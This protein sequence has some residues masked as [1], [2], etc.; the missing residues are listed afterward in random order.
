MKINNKTGVA[1]TLLSLMGCSG[2]VVGPD[3]QQNIPDAI[4]P[5]ESGP[6]TGAVQEDLSLGCIE[7]LEA[8]PFDYSVA[9]NVSRISKEAITRSPTPDRGLVGMSRAGCEVEESKR[10]V[11]QDAKDSDTFMCYLKTVSSKIREVKLGKNKWNYFEGAMKVYADRPAVDVRVRL[12][13]F[14]S[15]I[16]VDVCSNIPNAGYQRTV[17]LRLNQES[18]ATT[19]HVV[20]VGYEATN[21]AVLKKVSRIELERSKDQAGNVLSANYTSKHFNADTTGNYEIMHGEFSADVRKLT[22][23]FAGNVFNS[24][25]TMGHSNVVTTSRWDSSGY[26]SGKLS[27]VS[28]TNAPTVEQCTAWGVP[29][30]LMDRCVGRCLVNGEGQVEFPDANGKCQTN[31]GRSEAYKIVDAGGLLKHFVADGS[32]S[33]FL[34][35]VSIEPEISNLEDPADETKFSDDWDCKVGEGS[36]AVDS[37]AIDLIGPCGATLNLPSIKSCEAEIWETKSGA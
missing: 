12:G 36:L 25:P 10:M 29:D 17:E 18:L 4:E 22:N 34:D 30:W 23:S 1:V 2:T 14:G 7:S 27:V 19:G 31:L 35:E 26:G 3:E 32:F 11:F 33:S 28:E 13:K 9:G 24:S 37:S 21:Q 16:S 6:D 15:T 5:V 20:R 8:S